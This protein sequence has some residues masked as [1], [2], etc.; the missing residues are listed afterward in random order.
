MHYRHP[1]LESSADGPHGLGPIDPWLAGKESVT[2][3]ESNYALFT[4]GSLESGERIVVFQHSSKV[5][6]QG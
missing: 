3:L 4:T 6:A 5:R 1:D 2:R